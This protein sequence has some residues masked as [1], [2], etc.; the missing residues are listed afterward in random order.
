M[1]KHKWIMAAAAL[2]L[3]GA[4][5]WACGPMFPNPLLDDRPATL[6]GTPQNTFAWEAARLVPAGD[7]LKAKEAR[8]ADV[9]DKAVQRTNAG[10]SAGQAISLKAM[11]EAGT[12]DDAYAKGEGLPEAIRLYEAGAVDF[13][14]AAHLCPGVAVS[15][16]ADGAAASCAML[17]GAVLEGAANRFRGVLALPEKE[18]EARVVAAAFMLGRIGYL[19]MR[20]CDTCANDD[21]L[22]AT[23]AAFVQT[24][25]LATKNAPDPDGLAVA[26]FGE[27]ARLHLRAVRGD[28][29]RFCDWRDFQGATACAAGVGPVELKRAIALY[30]EQAARGSNGAVQSLRFIADDVL[31]VPATTAA[32]VDDPVAQRLLVTYALA[33]VGDIDSA[34]PDADDGQLDDAA[35]QKPGIVPHPRLTNLVDAISKKGLAHVSGADRLA[36]LAYRL[37]HYE[38]AATLVDKTGS[39]LS[40]WVAAKLALHRG[41]MAAANAAYAAAAKAFPQADD[42]Q[43]SIEPESAER[44]QGEHGVLALARGEYVEAIGHLYDAALAVGHG[45]D[46]D[47]DEGSNGYASDVAYIAERVLTVDELSAF[48]D[49]RVPASAPPAAKPVDGEYVPVPVADRLRASL[50]RRLMRAGRYDDA[51]AYLPASGDFR[52]GTVDLRAQA[53]EYA[54]AL[55]GAEHGWTRI[56]RARSWFTAATIARENGMALFGYEQGP[57]FNDNGGNFQGGSG[58][59]ANDLSGPFV[60]DGERKRFADTQP[61]PDR[62]LHYRYL[63]V[64]MAT[65]AADGLP[66]QSQAFAAVLCKATGWMMDGPPD[67]QDPDGADDKGVI[68]VSDRTK[69][70]DALYARYVRQGPHVPWAATFGHGCPSPDFQ[71]AS[72]LLRQ[73]QFV[74]AKHAIR[75]WLPYEIAILVAVLAGLAVLF[76][77]RRRTIRQ[78][79]S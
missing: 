41:D 24:R 34:R 67:Y 57:D 79:N 14:H 73:Q 74:A 27:Q 52:F 11:D 19:R 3:L 72:H 13:R 17:S 18:R 29:A 4:V 40:S 70:I 1:L 9:G 51:Q 8:T 62:R 50:G 58:H 31:R 26:S 46:I 42:P 47:E 37:G 49:S 55:H 33:R 25:E 43:A 78:R 7:A 5:A 15:G 64:D 59:D 16:A 45:S 76:R 60:T 77:R 61:R 36:A 66:P 39:P 38:L 28:V 20:A 75:R 30:A 35:T 22:A 54:K 56:G 68:H 65:R 23:E 71:A 63:A 2:P 6:K 44:I 12:G 48:V 53:G 32:L 21:T 69:R 10:F